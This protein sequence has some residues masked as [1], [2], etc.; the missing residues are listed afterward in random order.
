MYTTGLKDAKAP[1]R[2]VLCVG[3]LRVGGTGKSPLVNCLYELLTALGH[4]VVI[5]CSG[6]GSPAS[7]GAKIAPEGPLLASV[8]GDEPAMFRLLRPEAPLIVGRARVQAAELAHTNWPDSVLLMDDGFQHLP[9][10]KRC[11]IVLDAPGGNPFC[12]LAGPYREPRRNRRR[13]DLVM[14]GRF[15]VETKSFLDGK[16]PAS[17]NLLCALGNPEGFVGSVE[18][19]GIRVVARKFLPDHDDLQGTSLFGGLDVGIPTIVTAK[20]W[21]KLIERTDHLDKDIQVLHQRTTVEPKVEFTEW[22]SEKMA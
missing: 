21:V 10:K 9:L 3:N 15:N 12:L 20:D 11:S 13:A 22:I 2:R 7:E 17:A 5:G 4:Q 14:P 6:Y 18:A 8:W 1:H 16:A 19:L